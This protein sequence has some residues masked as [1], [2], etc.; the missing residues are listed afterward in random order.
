M[1]ITK[2]KITFTMMKVYLR[3]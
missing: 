3:F 1:S 2:D